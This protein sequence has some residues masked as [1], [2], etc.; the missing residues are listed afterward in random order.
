MSEKAKI[1]TNTDITS[2]LGKLL[3][4][5]RISEGLS[6]GDIMSMTL[7]SRSTIIRIEQG[8]VTNI[9]YYIAV[10]QALKISVLNDSVKYELTPLYELS[11]ERKKRQFLTV[12]VRK[13]SIDGFFSTAKSVT[14][15]IDKLVAINNYKKTKELSTNVSRV[16]LN[17]VEDNLLIKSKNGRNNL[18]LNN[19]N[20]SH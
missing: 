6:L 13:L 20:S 8:L 19:Q 5:K 10:G 9:H 3:K 17:L 4:E 14:N 15:V 18:Y 1:H 7:F 2:N 11:E 12:K 16:L